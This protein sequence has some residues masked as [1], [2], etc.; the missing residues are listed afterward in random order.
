LKFVAKTPI[1]QDLGPRKL[2][3][4]LEN[5]SENPMVFSKQK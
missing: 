5:S 2:K 3:K 1:K 4:E